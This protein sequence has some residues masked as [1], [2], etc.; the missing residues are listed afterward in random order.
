MTQSILDSSPEELLMQQVFYPEMTRRIGEVARSNSK[1]VHYTSAEVAVSIIQK[2]SIWMRNAITMNDFSEIEHGLRCIHAVWDAPVG[3]RFQAAIDAIHGGSTATVVEQ[4]DSWQHD[5][6]HSTF[7][8]CISEHPQAEDRHGRLSMWRAYGG[9]SGVALVLNLD[10]FLAA[11]D[12]LKA[13]SSPVLYADEA[14]FAEHLLKVAG[15][16]EVHRDVIAKHGRLYLEANIFHALR[17][18][19][20]CTKHH[21]FEE[22]REWRV[23]YSPNLA[24]SPAIE[25]SVET[26]RGIPQVVQKLPLVDRPEHGLHRADIPNILHKVIIGPTEDVLAVHGAF[27]VLLREAGVPNPE[28]RIHVSG[29]PLRQF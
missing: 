6:R 10:P 28:E 24:A 15:Q 25:P 23:V 1:F 7:L 27:V 13:Y 14:L 22:E 12:D 16:L 17:F 26:V 5:M 29:I 4:F 18:A 21:A 20:L 2:R 11:T 3:K 8:T 9:R 19:A